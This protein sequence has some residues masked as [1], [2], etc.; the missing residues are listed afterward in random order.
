MAAVGVKGLI[1]RA[2]YLAAESYYNGVYRV[3]G[4]W[5]F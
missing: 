4:L 1:Y 3:S 5:L 2:S